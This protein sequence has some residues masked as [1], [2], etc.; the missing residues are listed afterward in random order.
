MNMEQ[1]TAAG[2]AP[3]MGFGGMPLGI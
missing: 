3:I 2:N 1:I